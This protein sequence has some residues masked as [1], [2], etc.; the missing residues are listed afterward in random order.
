LVL[1]GFVHKPQSIA[2]GQIARDEVVQLVRVLLDF[3]D[4]L[5]EEQ[6]VVV[7]ADGPRV[8]L[9]SIYCMRVL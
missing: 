3:G 1:W 4:V 5:L 8:L 9:H 2:F 7:C 6:V